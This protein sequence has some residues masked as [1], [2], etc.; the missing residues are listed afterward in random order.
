MPHPPPPTL[1]PHSLLSELQERGA[2]TS[3]LHGS[4]SGTLLT[5]IPRSLHAADFRP[6][7]VEGLGSPEALGRMVAARLVVGLSPLASTRVLSPG[8]PG[9]GGRVLG[10]RRRSLHTH[11]PELQVF[12][13]G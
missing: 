10:R 13:V 12:P 5:T 11:L 9:D 1:K 8:L 6:R 4:A 2:A 3:G 7:H